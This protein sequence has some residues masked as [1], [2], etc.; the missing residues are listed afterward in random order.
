MFGSDL[1]SGD[2]GNDRLYAD[3]AG[4][5]GADTLSGGAG[6]DLLVSRDSL[7]DQLFGGRGNDTSTAD[8]EDDL[9]GVEST[10]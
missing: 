3:Y 5:D 4:G 8:E 1:L 7:A 2:G 10:S 6:D 9:A